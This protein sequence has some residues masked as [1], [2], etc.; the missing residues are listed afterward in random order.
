M[1]DAQAFLHPAARGLGYDLSP[2]ESAARGGLGHLLLYVLHPDGSRQLVLRGS[3]LVRSRL[4]PPDWME[5][6]IVASAPHR[7]WLWVDPAEATGPQRL[8]EVI[9]PNADGD[10]SDRV[11]RSVSL[12]APLPF[13]KRRTGTFDSVSEGRWQLAAEPSLQ[14]DDRSRS[15]L[16]AVSNFRTG[17]FH[18]YRLAD[19]NDDGDALD[20]GEVRL[21]FERRNA[22]GAQIA[23][24]LVV[25]DG[26]AHRELVVSGLSRP[27]TFTFSATSKPTVMREGQSVTTY[28]GVDALKGKHGTLRI[29][30]VTAATD[31]GGGYGAGTAKWSI[32]A[33]TGAY[34]GLQGGGRGTV[35]G[36]PETDLTRYEGYVSTS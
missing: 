4:F 23:P 29:P 6:Q 30:N 19:R 33:G 3:E 16:A 7:I 2:V 21:L 22:A 13:A 34:A 15:V 10:W 20:P 8:F 26:V 17:D 11:V 24:R 28:K 31:A 36:T 12:P 14:G 5:W 27:G 25:R 18:V 35:A 32:G 1:N 9:D